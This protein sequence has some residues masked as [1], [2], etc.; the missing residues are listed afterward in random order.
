MKTVNFTLIGKI[1]SI[2]LETANNAQRANYVITERFRPRE[3]KSNSVDASL[4]A[5]TLESEFVSDIKYQ[6]DSINRKG[7][8][9]PNHVISSLKEACKNHI[10]NC[11]RL[12]ITDLYTYVDCTLHILNG[13]DNLSMNT[14][15]DIFKGYVNNMI[16]EFK[17]FIYVPRPHGL[18]KLTS[19]L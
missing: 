19:L 11:G 10:S 17:D 14:S 2:K 15:N 8:L 16:G 6:I 4:Q 7:A 9:V 12:I 18:V 5:Y 3:L 13:A 1:V